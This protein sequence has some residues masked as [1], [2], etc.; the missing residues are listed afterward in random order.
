MCWLAKIVYHKNV[1]IV[2][3][4]LIK[5]VKPV[6]LITICTKL[7]ENVIKY[8]LM[9][10]LEI[11]KLTSVKYVWIIVLNAQVSISVIN[12]KMDIIL[13]ELF[14]LIKHLCNMGPCLICLVLQA[15][16]PILLQ[17]YT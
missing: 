7:K 13:L 2:Q 6:K 3:H 14:V 17:R 15:I 12:V 11:I 1:F 4:A 9:A 5:N 10:I 8:V 16:S